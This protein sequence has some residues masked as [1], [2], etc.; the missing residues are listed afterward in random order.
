LHADPFLVRWFV[1][2]KLRLGELR[3]DRRVLS[4]SLF[5][6]FSSLFCFPATASG[7]S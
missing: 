4:R 3:G 6:S 2:R 1:L 5:L 7:D